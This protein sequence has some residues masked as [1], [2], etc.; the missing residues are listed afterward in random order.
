MEKIWGGRARSVTLGP[1]TRHLFLC[2]GLLGFSAA[3][4]AQSAVQVQGV[5]DQSIQFNVAPGSS[6]TAPK[7]IKTALFELNYVGP[8]YPHDDSAPYFLFTALPCSGCS[9]EEA[10]YL[11]R[12]S[13]GNAS[14]SISSFVQPGKIFDPKNR[15]L[16]MESR[17]FYGHCLSSAPND[18]DDAF[19]VFQKERVD[20]RHG[21]QTSVYVAQANP[22]FLHERLIERGLPNINR[23]L[24]LVRAKKCHEIAARNRL[25]VLKPHGL[26]WRDLK[27]GD[28]DD[29]DGDTERTDVE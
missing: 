19:V 2:L 12:P 5:K 28:A 10:L 3:S 6:Q 26:N 15:A 29:D 20:R 13:A 4:F 17:A 1:M 16:V 25:Y 22:D 24:T 11:I 9:S 23:T 7:P 18:A 14:Q 21:L 27:P 8:L